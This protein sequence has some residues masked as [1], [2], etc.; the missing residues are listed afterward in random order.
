[1]L[2]TIPVPI[3]QNIPAT[4]SLV[5]GQ[6]K[7]TK[8]GVL[9]LPLSTNESSN[10]VVTL[11]NYEVILPSAVNQCLLHFLEEIHYVSLC[12]VYKQRILDGVDIFN[13]LCGEGS[14]ILVLAMGI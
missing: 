5:R 1:M 9:M 2:A 4:Q 11:K 14:S 8:T 13:L 7:H 12:R 6:I 10:F 3:R